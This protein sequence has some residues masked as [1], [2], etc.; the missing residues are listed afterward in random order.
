MT[1]KNPDPYLVSFARWVN[2]KEFFKSCSWNEFYNHYK[3]PRFENPLKDVKVEEL[4]DPEADN[5]FN[6][7][8]H[9]L[10]C[11]NFAGEEYYDKEGNYI[12]DCVD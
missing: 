8:E 9:D 6:E 10:F 5:I 4:L 1:N 11:G 3:K 7:M 12:G 2:R